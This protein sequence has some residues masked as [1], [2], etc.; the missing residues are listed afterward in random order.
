MRIP[1]QTM[2][3]AKVDTGLGEE[4]PPHLVSPARAHPDVSGVSSL[5][6][7]VKGLHRLL[8]G[9]VGVESMTCNNARSQK[10]AWVTIER[11][12]LGR[13]HLH[14]RRST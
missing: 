8:N 1:Q 6:D 9:G 7:I 10:S 13:Q 5:N 11:E 14:W 4:R 3:S 12:P 2:V